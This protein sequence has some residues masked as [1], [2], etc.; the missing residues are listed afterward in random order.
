M[1]RPLYEFPGGVHPPMHKDLS[2]REPIAAAPCPPR[3]ILPLHQHIGDAA[4]PTVNVGDHVLKGQRIA[5]AE[6][7]VSVALHAPTSG[8]V[9]AITDAPVPHPS[10]LPAPCIVLEAD[11]EDRWVERQPIEDYTT[12][13]P[14]HLRNIVRDAGIVGLGGAGFPSFIKLNPGTHQGVE[15]LI[16]NGI[17]CEPYITCDDM[18]MRER[19]DL[20]LAGIGIMRHAL[21]ARHVVIAVEDNKEIAY[22]TLVKV[23]A[24]RKDDVEIVMLPTVYPQGSEKQLIEVLTG[25][26]VPKNGLPIHIGIVVQNVATAAA[27]HRALVLGEPLISR[28]VTVT[29]SGVRRPRNMEV[30]IGTP[31]G[32]LLEWCDGPTPQTDR[33]IMG[34]PMMGFTVLSQDAP[35]IKTTN[36]LLVATER[37]LARNGPVLPCIRCGA[38]AQACPA[39]LLPQQLYWFARAKDFEQVQAHN[40]FDCIE[41]GCCAYVCPSNIPLVHYYRFAKTEIWSQE[42]E[43]EKADVARRRHEFRLE[44]MEREKAEKADRHKKKR[45]ELGDSTSAEIPTGAQAVQAAVERARARKESMPAG[46]TKAADESSPPPPADG[47]APTT[48]NQNNDSNSISKP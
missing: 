43:K 5:R 21:Q 14:S 36:C 12:M 30:R 6:G 4:A 2:T 34:G 28:I 11:G 32:Q 37:D 47:N 1:T 8:T 13:S 46:K 27:I 45:E 15:L 38:C 18:L 29:G 42:T 9:S 17:E 7:Y 33:V 3:L 26:E 19:A 25:K 39:S 40:V 44:R 41:C 31:I 48:S 20:I 24:Q 22:A 23:A 16:I 10:G 35:V